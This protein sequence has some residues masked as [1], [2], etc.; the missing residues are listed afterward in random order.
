MEAQDYARLRTMDYSVLSIQDAHKTYQEIKEHFE[1]HKGNGSDNVLPGGSLV[2]LV[3]LLAPL[4]ASPAVM[5]ERKK[6]SP[7]TE[8]TLWRMCADL[9]TEILKYCAKFEYY[10]KSKKSPVEIV[11]DTPND[12]PFS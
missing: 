7:H 5:D 9:Q 4:I 12:L 8:G 11:E 6:Q 1:N 10:A 2:G 3:G